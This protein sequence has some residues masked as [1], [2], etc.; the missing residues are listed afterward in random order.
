MNKPRNPL[1]LRGSNTTCVLNHLNFF[2]PPKAGHTPHT[3]STSRVKC[4]NMVGKSLNSMK[5]RMSSTACPWLLRCLGPKLVLLS[6]HRPKGY[7]RTEKNKN[8][9]RNKKMATKKT[10]TKSKMQHPLGKHS[11]TK[12]LRYSSTAMLLKTGK[13]IKR[14]FVEGALALR[15]GKVSN[16][17]ILKIWR[18]PYRFAER[19]A[20]CS[21]FQ[22]LHN[23]L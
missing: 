8:E 23:T 15:I 22:G 17:N 5:R 3:C 19:N 6:Y 18:T 7:F 11:L 13:I 20:C 21:V 9:V 14:P 2:V 4:K 1:M 16:S 10:R 12:Q